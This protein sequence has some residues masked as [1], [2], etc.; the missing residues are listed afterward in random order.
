MRI[1]HTRDVICITDSQGV[2]YYANGTQAP[3]SYATP[4]MQ[5]AS[6]YAAPSQANS[7]SSLTAVGRLSTPN[8]TTSCV[9]PCS[10]PQ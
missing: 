8:T 5:D 2:S 10:N 3:H 1:L 4:G 6:A 9:E 7:S